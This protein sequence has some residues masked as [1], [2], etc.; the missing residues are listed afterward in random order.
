M[1]TQAQPKTETKTVTLIEAKI[2]GDEKSSGVLSGYA[3]VTN[4]VDWYGDIILPGAYKN[5]E[6]MLKDGWSGFNH[7]Y[8]PVGYF[9]TAREDDRGLY[10][11]IEFHSTEDAQRVRT[12][13]AER[14]AAGKSVGMS[15]MFSTLEATHGEREGRDVRE[16]KAIEVIEAGFVLYPANTAATATGVKAGSGCPLDEQVKAARELCE[17]LHSRLSDLAEKRGGKLSESRTQEVDEMAQKWADLSA[18]LKGEDEDT[19]E[20]EEPVTPE[21]IAELAEFFDTM[22]E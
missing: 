17:D 6:R 13:A 9:K 12:K 3:S 14:I 16:L 10:V 19:T 5:L 11:E 7:S 22:E 18:K 21:D 15:I 2:T 1:P 4:N 20:P 8:D